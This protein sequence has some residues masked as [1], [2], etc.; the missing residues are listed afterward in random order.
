MAASDSE[1]LRLSPAPPPVPR[2]MYGEEQREGGLEDSIP[3]AAACASEGFDVDSFA[4]SHLHCPR[5]RK[6]YDDPRTL[7][8]LD[9]YC[10]EC[11]EAE[12]REQMEE[13]E[14]REREREEE[15]EEE[16]EEQL[17]LDSD[18]EYFE[19]LRNSYNLTPSNTG[20]PTSVI[21]NEQPLLDDYH[22]PKGCNGATGIR[23][24]DGRLESP[25]SNKFLCN[26]V[27][28]M[29]LKE[30]VPAGT[31]HCGN[32]IEENVA[33]AVC[34]NP[35]CA[36]LPLCSKCLDTHLKTSKTREHRIV[37]P[38]SK[39]EL[40]GGAG[41]GGGGGGGRDEW[42]YFVRRNWACDY[43]CN[44]F[45]DRYCYDHNKTV[46]MECV[47]TDHDERE[48]GRS[49]KVVKLTDECVENETVLITS[50]IGKFS[51]IH[52]K[53]KM[54]I[55]DVDKMKDSLTENKNWT[56]NRINEHCDNLVAS[57]EQQR[58]DLINETSRIYQK[59]MSNLKEHQDGLKLASETIQRSLDFIGGS[60]NMAI[61]TEF[62]FLMKSFHERLDRLT[63]LY[64]DFNKLPNDV[65][66]KIYLQ[67]N[68]G[69]S[70]DGALGSVAGNPYI[71]NYTLMSFPSRVHAKRAYSFTIQSRDI[72]KNEVA[73]NV[74]QLEA[75]ISPVVLNPEPISCFI[76]I[77]HEKGVYTIYFYPFT[78]GRHK[79]NVFSPQDRPL[80]D[81][82]VR[83][84]PFYIDVRP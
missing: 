83:G 20:T 76:R 50:R 39:M 82:F 16:E 77:N 36:N 13:R 24:E 28:D 61:P 79:I 17:D 35:E 41:G 29:K 59:K 73:G 18:E 21:G 60:V 62:M 38:D 72:C 74:P 69:F 33:I 71:K 19:S 51:E 46:C 67:L 45:V 8:C 42:K 84:C 14:R 47:G 56:L 64:K 52:D 31:I 58:A 3:S 49:C 78:A 7:P 43:H 34:N 70:V 30:E 11:L 1:E 75:T 48:C 57:L 5:C 2:P 68:E 65:N 26:F 15:D 4:R 10:R 22:C 9:S 80:D 27:H 53:I 12:L 63:E 40:E 66:D 44:F 25:P 54:A 55:V 81:L 32:C 37:C 23:I 6:Y